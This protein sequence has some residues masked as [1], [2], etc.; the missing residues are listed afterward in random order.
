MFINPL[1]LKDYHMLD[2]K[3]YF[4]INEKCS[5]YG[6]KDQGNIVKCGTYGKSHRQ[7]L[8]C[9]VCKHKFSETRNTAFFGTKYSDET[10]KRIILCVA[11]GNG[12]RNTARILGLSKDA[13][14]RIIKIAGEHCDNVLSNLLQSLSLEQC[15]MDELWSFISKK[16]LIQKSATAASKDESAS[17]QQ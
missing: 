12:V 9:N 11:E 14:N 7:M 6:L 3:N 4:C 15:Q 17:G 8:Q 13:V 16:K 10:I 2:I 5:H 1:N